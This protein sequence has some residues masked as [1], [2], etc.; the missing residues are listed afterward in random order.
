[1]ER[2]EQQI[3]GWR[4]FRFGFGSGDTQPD[5]LEAIEISKRGD[6]CCCQEQCGCGCYVSSVDVDKLD[7][8]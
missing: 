5:K 2:D 8:Q 4:S 6:A 1:M 3:T 7:Q